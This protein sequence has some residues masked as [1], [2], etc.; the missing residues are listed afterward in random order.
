[1]CDVAQGG[2]QR[3]VEGDEFIFNDP[4]DGTQRVVTAERLWRA[5]RLHPLWRRLPGVDAFTA[6]VAERKEP[7]VDAPLQLASA[8]R[9][10]AIG[11]RAE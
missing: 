3:G 9:P 2:S 11:P 5:W 7:C 10:G 4:S 8:C 1:M 6:F